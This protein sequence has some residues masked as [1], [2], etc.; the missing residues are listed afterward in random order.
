MFLNE[1]IVYSMY[2]VDMHVCKS[3]CMSHS[4]FVCACT[5]NKLTKGKYFVII[6]LWLNECV[7]VY[8]SVCIWR[9]QSAWNYTLFGKYWKE[10][11]QRYTIIH[12]L[13]G[14]EREREKQTPQL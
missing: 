14:R 2:S 4:S 13:H 8:V 6:Y 7:V 12:S 11:T 1:T 10:Y 3:V 9:V 5:I